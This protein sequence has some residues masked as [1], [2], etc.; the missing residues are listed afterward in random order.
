M[1]PLTD[2][3]LREPWIAAALS[4]IATG[5]LD[6]VRVEVLARDL[7]VTKGGFYWHFADREALLAAVLDSWRSGR[8]EAI[9]RQADEAGG[10]ARRRLLGL[11]RLYAARVNPQGI[12]IELA[13]RQW[14]RRDKAAARAA[15]A[16]DAAR[17]T[18]VRTLFEVLDL[19]ADEAR[20]RA[21]L[22]YSFLF[23]QSLL[24]APAPDR[25][26]RALIEACA[27]LLTG[28]PARGPSRAG[29]QRPV[30]TRASRRRSNDVRSA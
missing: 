1:P 21:Y 11:I 17:L 25:E 15:A 27:A 19:P 8:I 10:D 2:T 29:R 20:S 23:G 14:A 16:V 26:R 24:F 28:R 9:A 30:A 6:A 7:G 3:P 12:A 5:G 13:I 4:R 22:F 18:Q